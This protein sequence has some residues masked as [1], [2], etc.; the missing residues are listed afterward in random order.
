MKKICKCR[1][2]LAYGVIERIDM[3]IPDGY[4]SP[5]FSLGT[6]LATVP[7]WGVAVNRVRSVLNQRTV[8]L[9]AIFSAFAFTIMMFNIPVPGGT[10]AHAVGGT[11][12]AIVLGPWAAVIGVSTALIIQ[13][14]FFGD[15]GVLAIFANC[16]N[17]GVILP[18]VGYF[19]YRLLAGRS[20]LLSTRRVWAAGIGSYLAISVAALAVGIELGVQPLLFHQG[21]HPLY[22]PYSLQVAIPAMLLSHMFGAA[23]VEAL[24]TAFG[25][26]YIQKNY[27][28][29]LTSLRHV[30]SER[31][32]V[33]G[34]AQP[35]S[36]RWIFAV[37]L[38]AVL[39]ILFVVGLLT[40]HGNV[41]RLFG[42]DWS[43]VNWH[44]VM[45]MLLYV[46]VMAAILL[47]L[48]WYCLPRTY[49]KL[50]TIFVTL[51]VFVP[52]GLIAP[53]I[54]FGEGNTQHVKQAFGYIPTGL[55]RF[56]HLFSAPLDGYNVPLPF[57]NAGNVPL[58]HAALG[59][60]IS[61]IVGISLLGL[62][63]M[64]LGWLLGRSRST[65]RREQRQ[66]AF[67]STV[68]TTDY[69]AHDELTG[70]RVSSREG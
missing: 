17:M 24:V 32:V 11:L 2:F 52:L 25:L 58:W 56:S 66:D 60:E 33:E 20:S 59:Y 49:R 18:F 57:F 64:G 28:R 6:G 21:D 40:G 5:V 22:S 51:A 31:D 70:Q 48:A 36:L 39:V 16:L 65:R 50:G 45:V 68:V 4:L 63:M 7:M 37:G 12:I 15:G 29:Y 10:T 30:V 19:C 8:P 67:S 44:D 14:L 13:A 46:L 69:A 27:P 41:A 55:Q 42:A 43:S 53:G 26:A 9:L 34:E 54:A 38:L 23:L 47:P 62:L 35:L 61:G 3:H 1:D